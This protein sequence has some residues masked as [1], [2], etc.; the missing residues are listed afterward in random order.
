[1]DSYEDETVEAVV[2]LPTIEEMREQLESLVSLNNDRRKRMAQEFASEINPAMITEIRLNSLMSF[3]LDEA[4]RLKVEV[5]AEG[6]LGI[7]LDQA[8]SNLATA[9]SRSLL[10]DGVP[11]VDAAAIQQSLAK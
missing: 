8:L 9:K 1:M 5:V 6:T 11:G 7:M 10:L 2:G 4:A 3:I